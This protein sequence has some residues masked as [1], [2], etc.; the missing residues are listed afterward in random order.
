MVI[1]ASFSVPSQISGDH[2]ADLI[3]KLLQKD[4]RKRIGFERIDQILSHPFF[5]TGLNAQEMGS[6]DAPGRVF[7]NFNN[8]K[9]TETLL[10]SGKLDAEDEERIN[11]LKRVHDSEEEVSKL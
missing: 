6:L 5:S 10:T 9:D 3:R 7:V 8:P 11:S 4:L 2:S 1:Q